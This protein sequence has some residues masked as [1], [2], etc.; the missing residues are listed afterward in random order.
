MYTCFNSISKSWVAFFLVWFVCLAIIGRSKLL[1][2][3]DTFWH[4]V[5]GQ[6]ILDSF[7]LIYVDTFTY[8]FQGE[9]WIAN[10]WLSECTMA[11]IDRCAGFDGLVFVTAAAFAAILAW[12]GNRLVSRGLNWLCALLVVA[13]VFASCTYNLHVR[14]HVTTMF[15]FAIVF[16]K[17]CDFERDKIDVKKLW[18]LVP[19][20]VFWTN[21]HGGVLG[22]LGTL[23]VA[24]FGW[25]AWRFCGL[26]SPISNRFIA[27]S[28]VSITAACAASTLVNPYGTLMHQAWFTI[29]QADLSELV[30]EHAPL[31]ATTAE[32]QM[33]LILGAVYLFLIISTGRRMPHITW[34]IPLVWFFLTM[35]R[36]R[37]GPLFAISAGI[38]LADILPH[39]R[40]AVW[41]GRRGFFE[42]GRSQSNPTIASVIGLWSLAL[43]PAALFGVACA[44]HWS[45]SASAQQGIWARQ[46]PS[47]WPQ[48]LKPLL[49]DIGRSASSGKRIFNEQEFGGFLIYSV[50]DLQ[51]FIDGRCELFGDEF[52]RRYML[53]RSDHEIIKQWEHEFGFDVAL[54]KTGSPMDRYFEQ[55]IHW[56]SIQK[57]KAATLYSRHSE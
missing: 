29:L 47:V 48:E 45:A 18:W 14:P 42:S 55:S 33:V 43:I 35:K 57:T 49:D 41:L 19:L 1:Q 31:D 15:L 51:I 54:T 50:P 23:L 46:H 6:E 28:L 56:N 13:L 27:L 26:S 44:N 21:L 9:A 40:V 4:I 2:D 17:L 11:V 12:I 30:I 22:G 3:P 25:T 34:L 7:E 38:A 37:H 32:G 39:S 53:A 52:L 5:V 20:F 24:I 8:T 16:G 36:I 10:Q